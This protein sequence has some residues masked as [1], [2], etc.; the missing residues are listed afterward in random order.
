MSRII[1]LCMPVVLAFILFSCSEKEGD[2]DDNIKLSKK[3]VEFSAAGDSVTVTTI[4]NWWWVTDV[5]LNGTYFYGFQEITGEA[6]TYKIEQNGFVVE[7]RNK[8]TLFIKLDENTGN[9]KRVMVVGL[10]AGNYFD[11]VTI[12]QKPQ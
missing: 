10:Q 12:T 2:W 5:S 11:R 3:S 8:N 9:T 7:R 4:G 1:A 6:E